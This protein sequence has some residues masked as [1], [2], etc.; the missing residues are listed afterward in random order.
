MTNQV[1]GIQTIL[2][3]KK[4]IMRI[5]QHHDSSEVNLFTKYSLFIFNFIF[6]VAGLALAAMSIWLHI[7][8]SKRIYDSVDVI[9][10]VSIFF[11]V[12]GFI[13]TA[14]STVGCWGALR[15]NTIF[16]IIYKNIVLILILSEAVLFTFIV[17]YT[18]LPNVRQ[19]FKLFPEES[20]QK[21]MLKYADDS[22]KN[23]DIRFFIDN[24][25]LSLKC[26]GLSNSDEGYKDWAKIPDFRCYNITNTLLACSVPST[27]C[28]TKPGENLDVF[29]GKGV[30]QL[31][32]AEVK[33]KIYTRGCL[34]SFNDWVDNNGFKIAAVF[35]TII[36]PQVFFLCVGNSLLDQIYRQKAKWHD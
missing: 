7:E 11:I 12:V 6:T 24:I 21:S 13:T 5:K 1:V 32:F 15:E 10:D 36:I 17:L 14:V 27:C 4:K 9:I 8:K 22:S 20:F 3:R 19:A 30:L 16:I 33:K 18:T 2:P 25:H 23:D 34:Q 35:V 31:G 26:C 29:C 28:R